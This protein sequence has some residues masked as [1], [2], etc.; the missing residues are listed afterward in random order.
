MTQLELLGEELDLALTMLKEESFV[1]LHDS[2]W[3]ENEVDM[4]AA[5]QFT[6]P[7]HIGAM[8]F[9]AGGLLCLKGQQIINEPLK[10]TK[11]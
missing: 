4:A 11:E 8:R 3:R 1:L 9:E 2:V 6:S 10:H 5:A 7:E